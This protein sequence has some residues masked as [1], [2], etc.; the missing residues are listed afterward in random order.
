[1]AAFREPFGRIVKAVI[2]FLIIM[3]VWLTIIVVYPPLALRLV[4]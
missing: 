2:P 1:M 4:G 3:L